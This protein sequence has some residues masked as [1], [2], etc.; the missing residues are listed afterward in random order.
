LSVN[1]KNDALKLL[2][3]IYVSLL[4]VWNEMIDFEEN[5]EAFDCLDEGFNNDGEETTMS[6]TLNKHNHKCHNCG[7]LLNDNCT[8]DDSIVCTHC[9][10]VQGTMVLRD[11]EWRQ[12]DDGKQ[13]ARS[14]PTREQ[15]DQ[16]TT[17]LPTYQGKKQTFMTMGLRIIQPGHQVRAELDVIRVITDVCGTLGLPQ[18]IIDQATKLCLDTLYPLPEIL[19]KDRRS[20]INPEQITINFDYMQF[21]E[22]PDSKGNMI[23]LEEIPGD[24]ITAIYRQGIGEIDISLFD[25]KSDDGYI[26]INDYLKIGNFWIPNKKFVEHN[27]VRRNRRYG[28]YAAC[29]YWSCKEE[30][31][32]KDKTAIVDAFKKHGMDIK[33]N[34]IC[35]GLSKELVGKESRDSTP[36]DFVDPFCRRIGEITIGNSNYSTIVKDLLMEI[37]K[38]RLDELLCHAPKSHCAGVMFYVAKHVDAYADYAQNNAIAIQQATNVSWATINK[39]YN[40][41]TGLRDNRNRCHLTWFKKIMNR[42]KGKH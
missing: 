20:C 23:Q 22:S 4:G 11:A 30:E 17:T 19:Y 25:S 9:S 41:L 40:N 24:R 2:K 31:A 15:R 29:I 12:M 16:K 13:T 37:E 8:M 18:N 14:C 35:N 21:Y 32:T 39:W 5:Q 6:K 3:D 1:S 42:A 38:L 34:N 33:A 7:E 28:L 27:T 36:L 10:A 26:F